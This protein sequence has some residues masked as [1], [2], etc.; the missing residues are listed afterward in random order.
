M[1]E[2]LVGRGL[3]KVRNKMNDKLHL[4]IEPALDLAT[5]QSPDT[6]ITKINEAFHKLYNERRQHKS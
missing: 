4:V 1:A 5:N 2:R 3:R 6:M